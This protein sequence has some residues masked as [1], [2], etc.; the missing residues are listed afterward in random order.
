M[1][2][3][4]LNFRWAFNINDIKYESY[5]IPYDK[6]NFGASLENALKDIEEKINMTMHDLNALKKLKIM[7]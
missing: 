2:W 1:V 4:T 3:E 5:R 7:E 6:D